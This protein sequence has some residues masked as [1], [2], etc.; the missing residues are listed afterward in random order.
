MDDRPPVCAAAEAGDLAAVTRILDTDPAQVHAT[1]QLG[2]VGPHTPL[3]L[4]AW[5]GHVEVAR[6]LLD[7]GAD[8][9]A[10]GEFGSTP[11][12]YAVKHRV[13]EVV[14][15]LLDRGANPD[16]ADDGRDRPLH[17]CTAGFDPDDRIIALLEA[18]GA[19]VDLGLALAFGRHEAAW[20]F[21]RTG[22]PRAD[23]PDSDYLL[24]QATAG[25]GRWVMAAL[26]AAGDETHLD[27]AVRVPV[28]AR[29]VDEWLPLLDALIACQVSVTRRTFVALRNAFHFWD[30]R[31]A[32]RLLAAGVLAPFADRLGDLRFRQGLFLHVRMVNQPNPFRADFEAMLR[33]AGVE[34]DGADPTG[35]G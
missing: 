15:L 14:A 6:L 12:H 29:V 22:A 34:L 11:L 8:P 26:D 1:S 21:L 3:H 7:R 10:R 27:P 24:G 4:A 17:L 13:D 19:T 25:M 33:A 18:A 9:N 35:R 30:R 23:D 31:P 16:A 28:T 32:E 5:Q 2:S 20:A